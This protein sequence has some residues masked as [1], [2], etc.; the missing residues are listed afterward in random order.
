MALK[1]QE[2]ENTL[3]D[4]INENGSN[5]SKGTI[6]KENDF[7][8]FYKD[9]FEIGIKSE[10]MLSESEALGL[11]D[12]LIE[13]DGDY[14]N[15]NDD[16]DKT[17]YAADSVDLNNV[18]IGIKSEDYDNDNDDD[19][20]DEDED[21]RRLLD[22]TSIEN[23]GSESCSEMDTESELT[24]VESFEC[25]MCHSRFECEKKL[26]K[27]LSR[28]DKTV[29]TAY[30]ADSV[31]LNNDTTES[32]FDKILFRSYEIAQL[33][34][35][36]EEEFAEMRKKINELQAQVQFVTYEK[37]EAKKALTKANEELADVRRKHTKSLYEIRA[38]YENDLKEEIKRA[39]ISYRTKVHTILDENI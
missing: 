2:N 35:V 28:H 8:S 24:V 20:D 7:F 25:F 19:D 13:E 26:R 33:I 37:D 15:D 17:A 4:V 3:N 23:G 29:K 32:G 36:H 27:H 18:E 38:K 1:Q 39:I 9:N 22:F 10:A 5:S 31:D 16:D 30:A 21:I 6:R 12:D 11:S 34:K 14:D